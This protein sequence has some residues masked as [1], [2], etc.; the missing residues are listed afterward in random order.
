MTPLRPEETLSTSDFL[1]AKLRNGAV[2]AATFMTLT[3]S[4]LGTKSLAEGLKPGFIKTALKNDIAAGMLSGVPAGIMSAQGDSL[5]RGHGFANLKDTAESAVGFAMI[6]G[7]MPLGQ[8]GL[9]MLSERVQPGPSLASATVPIERVSARDALQLKNPGEAPPVKPIEQVFKPHEIKAQAEW[10]DVQSK[11][12]ETNFRETDPEMI[13]RLADEAYGRGAQVK[14]RRLD[15]LLG[16]CGAGKSRV[17]ESLARELGAMTPDS[18][19]I[20]AQIPGYE[21][22]MGNQAVHEDSSAAYKIL[23]DRALKAGDNIVWQGVGKTSSSVVDL[24]TQAKENGYE[25]HVHMIDAP[26]EVAAQRVHKRASGEPDANGIRQMIPPEV[27]LNPKYQ[28]VPRLNFFKMIGDAALDFQSTGQKQIDGFR[29]WRSTD[30]I[31]GRLPTGA[32]VPTVRPMWMPAE[33][34][35]NDDQSDP[36]NPSTLFNVNKPDTNPKR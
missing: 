25:V 22:G 29:L 9:S 12:K 21:K 3:G 17:T 24:I 7:M 13:K 18:D 4:M 6:G 20:K 1:V 30:S 14:G 2:G 31:S 35:N 5:L 8:K 28:Y 16:N 34:A 19:H 32:V 15:I 26:P 10:K 23:L 27:P 36:S 33:R 11:M